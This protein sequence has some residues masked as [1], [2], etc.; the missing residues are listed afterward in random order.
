[1]YIVH[2]WAVCPIMG[3]YLEHHK[4]DDRQ[5]ANMFAKEHNGRVTK[6]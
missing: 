2:Y 1:M 4:F 5:R 3:E 6:I